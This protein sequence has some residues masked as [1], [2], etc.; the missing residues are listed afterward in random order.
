VLEHP[1]AEVLLGSLMVAAL[2]AAIPKR[3]YRKLAGER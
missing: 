1:P 3:Y 2:T